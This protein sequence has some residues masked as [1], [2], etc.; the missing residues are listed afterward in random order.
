MT[1]DHELVCDYPSWV[2][3]GGEERELIKRFQTDQVYHE[4]LHH[5]EIRIS[6]NVVILQPVMVIIVLG[7]KN[8]SYLP[9]QITSITNYAN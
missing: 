7:I 6:K 8:S 1:R 5:I 9:N 4:F 2:R 3:N